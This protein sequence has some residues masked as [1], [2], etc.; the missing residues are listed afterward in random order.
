LIAGVVAQNAT[1]V[2][3]AEI[4]AHLAGLTPTQ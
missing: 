3:A 4:E 1:R 2:T